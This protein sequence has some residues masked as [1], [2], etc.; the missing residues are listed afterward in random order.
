MSSSTP[1]ASGSQPTTTGTNMPSPAFV[2]ETS[3]PTMDPNDVQL[4]PQPFAGFELMPS[5]DWLNFDNA[6]ENMDTLLGS[7]GADLSMELL[8]PFSYDAWAFQPATG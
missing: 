1:A 3:L 4:D 2:H 6:F 5:Q 8:R 7:S